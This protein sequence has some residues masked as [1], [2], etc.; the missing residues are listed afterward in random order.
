MPELVLTS[1][2][3]RFYKHFHLEVTYDKFLRD[4]V[5]FSSFLNTS[6]N[7]LYP[8]MFFNRYK[9]NLSYIYPGYFV[10]LCVIVCVCVSQLVA[11]R[12][13]ILLVLVIKLTTRRRDGGFG[14]GGIEGE[15]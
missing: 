2:W 4:R 3:E 1:G 11:E 9:I 6:G 7:Y 12:S 13:A 8:C 10:C 15:R 5:L 14:E